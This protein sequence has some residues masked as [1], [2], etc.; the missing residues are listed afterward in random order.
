MKNFRWDKKYL[1]WGVTAF[2]VIACSVIFFFII[3]NWNDFHDVLR[4]IQ[5]S[6]S[7]IIIGLVLAYLL[8]PGLNA[9]ERRFLRPWAK[10]LF[11]DDE[12]KVF[13]FARAIGIIIMIIFLLIVLAGMAT[14]VLPQLYQSVEK[15][16]T[17]VDHYIEVVVQW[18]DKYLSENPEMESSMSNIISQVLKY[19]ADWL[20]GSV[21]TR[22]DTIIVSVTSGL[23]SVIMALFNFFIGIIV[24]VYVLYSKEKF[25]A[26]AK[27]VSFC[28]M[29]PKRANGILEAFRKADE[30]FAGFFIGKILDSAIIGILCG[31]F[32]TAVNMPYAALVSVVVG[33][34]NVVPFFGPYFGAIPCAFIILLESPMMCLV[35]IIFCIV[36]QTFDGHILGPK[37]LGSKTNLS[38]FWVV[39]AIL[40]SGG[41]FGF[42]GMVC[43]VPVFA[44]IY[45][46][47]QRAVR[48]RLAEK[49]LPAETAVYV[50]VDVLDEEANALVMKQPA[51][52][53]ERKPKEKK[54]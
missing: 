2:C 50:D 44:V 42:V 22:I 27:K 5:S 41:L 6:L 20:Q 17:S 47:F 29:R 14:L 34:T 35:F 30:M 26:Q 7:P 11:K 45:Y 18:A 52:Q 25:C 49:E 23:R 4:K 9:L 53:H 28:F 31:I 37:I 54:K 33:V 19:L 36:L 32:T 24:S 38:S 13:A 3:N 48:R 51:Q 39:F 12:K 15:L 21:L 1:Y 16:I 10:K 46:F 43:G 40:L 8:R